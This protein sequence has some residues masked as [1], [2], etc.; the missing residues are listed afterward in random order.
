M[1]E[2]LEKKQG[3]VHV[4]GTF[5]RSITSL[6]TPI[7]PTQQEIEGIIRD[8]FIPNNGNEAVVSNM[9]LH[10]AKVMDCMDQ[11]FTLIII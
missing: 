2:D 9:Q 7:I 4:M 1:V 11:I 10:Q 8:L 6:N 3:L 5:T